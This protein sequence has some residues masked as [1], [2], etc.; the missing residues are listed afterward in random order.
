MEYLLSQE[1]I[2]RKESFPTLWARY[3]KF[4]QL[5]SD[6][7]DYGF[8][9]L[10]DKVSN[11]AFSNNGFW[12]EH[13]NEV[14][15][16][17]KVDR[18]IDI[19]RQSGNWSK[20]LE[21]YRIW[22][23]QHLQH[24]E[25]EEEIWE[26]FLDK[27]G[28]VHQERC[29]LINQE[30]I[31]PMDQHDHNLCLQFYSWI[32]RYLSTFGSIQQTPKDATVTFVRGL[33]SVC[34]AQQWARFMPAVHA[35]CDDTVWQFLLTNYNI[36][37]A[38]PVASQ[39]FGSGI[40]TTDHSNPPSSRA[41]PGDTEGR[42]QDNDGNQPKP[43]RASFLYT[44]SKPEVRAFNSFYGADL[45]PPIFQVSEFP[46]VAT[47]QENNAT[48]DGSKSGSVSQEVNSHTNVSRT[49]MQGLSLSG[50]RPSKPLPA[51]SIVASKAVPSANWSRASSRR[52]GQSWDNF[53][54]WNFCFCFTTDAVIVDDGDEHPLPPSPRVAVTVTASDDVD[55]FDPSGEI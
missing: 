6:M 32:V 29:Q 13:Q 19:G 51:R 45:E 40:V 7:E 28:G 37:S 23:K 48:I 2:W 39:L 18:A 44:L 33:R 11:K 16:A 22:R 42:G 27:Y 25:H 31:T 20:V 21:A 14:S 1:E 10:L 12:E 43:T 34:S 55:K 9:P 26:N 3:Q 46:L 41:T 36:H 5:H 30:V 38:D 15:S 17:M 24:I 49:P 35:V 50:Q 4:A 53:I 54:A 8:F 47:Q 52:P